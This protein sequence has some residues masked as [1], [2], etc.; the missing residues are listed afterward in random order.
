M[1]GSLEGVKKSETCHAERSEAS[2]QFFVNT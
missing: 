1:P 2:L